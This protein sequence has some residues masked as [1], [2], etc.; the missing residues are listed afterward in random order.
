MEA[1]MSVDMK[2]EDAYESLFEIAELDADTDQAS[3]PTEAF[4]A[5]TARRVNLVRDTL[6]DDELKTAAHDFGGMEPAK[7]ARAML[8]IEFNRAKDHYDDEERTYKIAKWIRI[9]SVVVALVLIV[10][11]AWR[12][13]Q[14]WDIEDLLPAAGALVTGT[15]VA[16][17]TSFMKKTAIARDKAWTELGK[18]R[19]RDT[20]ALEKTT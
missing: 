17:I 13:T 4:A 14:G 8:A 16:P 12:F 3:I 1:M 5:G 11:L 20:T 19:E 7:M 9:A 15:L 2:L 18:L 6:T 10:Y